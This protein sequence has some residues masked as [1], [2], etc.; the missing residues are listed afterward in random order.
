[1]ASSHMRMRLQSPMLTMS[2]TAPMVQ[3]CV[4]LA[5]AP[6]TKPSA[7]APHTTIEASAAGLGSAKGPASRLFLLR[8]AL[9]GLLGRGAGGVLL[10]ERAQ[11]LARC[12]GLADL[13]LRARD[14]EQRVGRLGVLRP[15]PHH[16]LLRGDRRLVVA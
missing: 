15:Q 12:V 1:M 3:K 14:L 5:T 16:L 4:L 6:K 13:G 9:L 8:Q 2:D 11:R 7:N 10:D